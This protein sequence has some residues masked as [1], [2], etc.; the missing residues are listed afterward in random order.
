M[1][2]ERREIELLQR[3]LKCI[4][5]SSNEE[6][7]DEIEVFLAQPEQTE[8]IKKKKDPEIYFVKD[9]FGTLRPTFKNPKETTFLIDV[10]H[11]EG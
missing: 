7:C 1:S 4:G 5:E 2:K 9:E 8:Y 3:A 6:L 10:L 11:G